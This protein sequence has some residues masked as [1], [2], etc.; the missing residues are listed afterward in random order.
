MSETN[1]EVVSNECYEEF[2]CV[3]ALALVK[4]LSSIRTK[5]ISAF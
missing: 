4:R 2:L 3:S 1:C 5:Q